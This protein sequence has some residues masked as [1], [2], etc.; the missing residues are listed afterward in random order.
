MQD[1]CKYP[2]VLPY[3]APLKVKIHQMAPVVVHRLKR[4]Q[5]GR[6]VALWG[7]SVECISAEMTK[8][9]PTLH[10]NIDYS[11]ASYGCRAQWVLSMESSR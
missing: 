8:R 2:S 7:S 1:L 10:R 11:T 9:C 6:W 4:G 3:P 5:T